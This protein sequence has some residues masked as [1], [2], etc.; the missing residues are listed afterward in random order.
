MST[1]VNQ[2]QKMSLVTINGY[3]SSIVLSLTILKV[4]NNTISCTYAY[5]P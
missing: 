2:T 4:G 1:F 3:K 5:L